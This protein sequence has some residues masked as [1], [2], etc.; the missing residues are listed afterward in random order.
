MYF[1]VRY[2]YFWE[3]GFTWNLFIFISSYVILF[4]RID[5]G[6]EKVAARIPVASKPSRKFAGV[7]VATC[8]LPARG[9]SQIGQSLAR[10][11]NWN[12]MI[13]KGKYL[14][15]SWN[16]QSSTELNSANVEIHMLIPLTFHTFRLSSQC[17]VWAII[18]GSGSTLALTST[19]GRIMRR[20][21]PW[22][23]SLRGMLCRTARHGWRPETTWR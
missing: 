13:T 19:S 1:S 10:R 14:R 11:L 6:K 5:P 15:Y 22:G 3:S 20:T 17:S 12:G 7:V 2:A 9:K 23:L 21:T 16:E 8:G 18:G 4:F